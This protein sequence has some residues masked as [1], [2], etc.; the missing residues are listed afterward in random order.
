MRVLEGLHGYRR[1]VFVLGDMLE[2][3]TRAA[4]LH[5]A[6]GAEIAARDID[7]LVLVGE[8]AKAAGAGALEAGMPSARVVH[9][10]DTAEAAA[11]LD[12]LLARGD[13][14]LLKAS[15]AMRFERIVEALSAARGGASPGQAGGGSGMPLLREVCSL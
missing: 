14:V 11:R 9:F 3:G 12:A 6:V 4:E 1:R 15:R 7:V 13:V 8:L 2:L 5:H 10:A